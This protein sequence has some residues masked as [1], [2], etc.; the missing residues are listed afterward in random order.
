MVIVNMFTCWYV[1]FNLLNLMVKSMGGGAELMLTSWKS[2]Y[3]QDCIN[4]GFT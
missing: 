4:R 3:I 2:D 1:D